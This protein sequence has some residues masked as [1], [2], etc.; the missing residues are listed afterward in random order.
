VS[1]GTKEEKRE[2]GWKDERRYKE[3]SKTEDKEGRKYT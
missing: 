1:E 3:E 2:K